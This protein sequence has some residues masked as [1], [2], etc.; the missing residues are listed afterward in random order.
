MD[1]HS[2]GTRDVAETCFTALTLDI[3]FFTHSKFERAFAT[4]TS[5]TTIR[6]LSK[7]SSLSF[8][9][10]TCMNST[11][12]PMIMTVEMV[13]C[14]T[15]RAFL[16]GKS[17]PDSNF[18]P[19]NSE[20]G[21]KRESK[22]AAYPP[23]NNPMAIINAT[24]AAQNRKPTEVKSSNCLSTKSLNTGNKRATIS[25]EKKNAITVVISDSTRNCLTRLP[26]TAPIAFRTPISFNLLD[27]LAVVRFV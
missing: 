2:P 27:A 6:F 13:N 4:F 7:P 11:M 10:R 23:D 3:S 16:T 8:R 18:K 14:R 1:F 17:P 15:T 9:K 20:T 24:A 22:I 19:F 25:T 5:I 26:R 21:L 12:V